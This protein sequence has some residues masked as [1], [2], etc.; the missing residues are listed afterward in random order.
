M[1]AFYG[2]GYPP[3]GL[4]RRNSW[5]NDFREQT[6]SEAQPD[7][8]EGVITEELVTELPAT[9]DKETS[10]QH[11]TNTKQRRKNRNKKR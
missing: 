2:I 6:R 3:P 1:D 7:Q 10:S 5:N 11:T 4:E 9:D 8:G